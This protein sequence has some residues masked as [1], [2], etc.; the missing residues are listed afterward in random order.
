MQNRKRPLCRVKDRPS[1]VRN[2]TPHSWRASPSTRDKRQA[3]SNQIAPT[4]AKRELGKHSLGDSFQRS[5][6]PT[7]LSIAATIP[8]YPLLWDSQPAHSRLVS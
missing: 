8:H 3:E 5:A 2:A 1:S 6:G 7:N 4:P